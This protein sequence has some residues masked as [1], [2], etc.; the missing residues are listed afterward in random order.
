M[1]LLTVRDLTLG[2]GGKPVVEHLSFELQ[3]GD[4]LCILGENGSGKTTLM[5]TLLGLQPPLSG[6]L[7][8]AEG[9][10]NAMGYLPQQ[11]PAQKDFPASVSEVVLSGFQGRMGIRPFYSFTE[12]AE[13]RENME[14]T[15]VLALQDRCYRELSGGQQQRVLLSRALCAASK[16]LLLDEPASGLDPEA[17]ATLYDII[18]GLNRAGMTIVMITHDPDVARRYAS[19]ILHMGKPPVLVPKTEHFAERGGEKA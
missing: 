2:Y 9:L 8:W 19:H 15:G 13:A 18:E 7:I 3:G 5:R 4:Y 14:K 10:K 6:Q 17:R 1:T 11:T 16:V 12:K